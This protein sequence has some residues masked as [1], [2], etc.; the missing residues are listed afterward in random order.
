MVIGVM[1]YSFAVGSLTSILSSID[2]KQAKLKE[3]L[4]I[5]N[6]IKRQ[7]NLP[8]EL[9]M[10]LRQSLKYDHRR[11][12]MDRFEFLN[13]LP[14]TLKLELSYMM[15][16]E[17]IDSFPFFKDKS[18]QFVAYIGPLL[19][20]QR[21]FKD[22]YVFMEGDPVEEIC[23]LIKGSVDLVLPKFDDA[24]FLHIEEGYYFGEL[25]FIQYM[26]GNDYSLKRQFTVKANED[27]EMLCLS[28]KVCILYIYI[29][30]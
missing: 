29:Y 7:F 20:P 6:G 28:R 11:N 8:M 16:H 19:R 25:D 14:N 27:C 30:I 24:P 1:S 18:K 2:S 22:E 13:E 15:H 4:D 5:L 10:R 17:I 3:K 9:Y 21:L 23:F 12:A 26:R